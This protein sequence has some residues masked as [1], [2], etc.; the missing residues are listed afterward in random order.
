METL[1]LDRKTGS[2]SYSFICSLALL[3]YAGQP[4]AAAERAERLPPDQIGDHGYA[5]LFALL[6][7]EKDVSKLRIIKH[8]PEELKNL[9]K[10][11][12]RV[13]GEAHKKIE[14]FGKA[15]GKLNLKDQGLPSAEIETRKAISK[16]KEKALLGSKGKEFKLELLLDQ[17][18]ALMYGANLARVVAGHENDPIRAEFLRQ[19]ADNLAKLQQRV[20][21]MLH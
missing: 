20:R 11:I 13:C 4:A 6:G 12:S 14:A 1:Q 10:E 21:T 18:E 5:L 2:G 9:T 15:D 17:N 19:L 16:T 3:L 8:E 7:D